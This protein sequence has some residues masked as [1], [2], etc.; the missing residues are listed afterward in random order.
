MHASVL[1][2]VDEDL[3]E[4]YEDYYLT[5]DEVF[6]LLKNRITDVDY[7]RVME[8]NDQEC[9][10]MIFKDLD[11]EC[12][13]PYFNIESKNNFNFITTNMDEIELFQFQINNL[14]EIID[15]FKDCAPDGYY[16]IRYRIDN[17][18]NLYL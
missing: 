13:K 8:M 4:N 12:F 10:S 17:I 18:F 9:Q 15:D 14:E 2:L 6:E 3:N 7:T 1:I 11:S 16:R 5:D